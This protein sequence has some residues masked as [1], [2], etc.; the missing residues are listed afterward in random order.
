MGLILAAWLSQIEI[1]TLWF[2]LNRPSG[3]IQSLSRYICQLC[4]F[5]F[6]CAI[7]ENPIPGGLETSGLR[8]N[9]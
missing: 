4:V 8:A 7:V 6:V 3:L 1:K 2:S 9:R 5:V